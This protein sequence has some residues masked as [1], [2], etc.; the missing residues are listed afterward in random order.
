MGTFV[1]CSQRREDDDDEM[2]ALCGKEVEITVACVGDLE[3]TQRGRIGIDHHHHELHYVAH[4]P[5]SKQICLALTLSA[6]QRDKKWPGL[7]RWS[8]K[9]YH[10]S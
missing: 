7:F 8:R 5:C 10:D 9:L 3:S 2:R 4:R 1:H 6:P